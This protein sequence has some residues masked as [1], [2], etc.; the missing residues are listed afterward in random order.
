[1]NEFETY[2]IFK[3]EVE[4]LKIRNQEFIVSLSQNKVIYGTSAPAKGNT[5]LNYFEFDKTQISKLI[6][7]NPLV[8]NLYSP[9]PIF[10]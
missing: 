1:M 2:M 5:L 7:L 4:L 8:K 6:E 3:K 9:G 10:Q